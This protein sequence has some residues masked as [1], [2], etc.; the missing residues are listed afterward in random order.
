M[1]L[2]HES[3]LGEGLAN[4]GDGDGLL[5]GHLVDHVPEYQHGRAQLHVGEVFIVILVEFVH[6]VRNDGALTRLHH[7]FN[8]QVEQGVNGLVIRSALATPRRDTR[9]NQHRLKAQKG[10]MGKGGRG[11]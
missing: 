8:G 10:G 9:E 2:V 7:G 6:N 1:R 3:K 5:G 4:V 11:V